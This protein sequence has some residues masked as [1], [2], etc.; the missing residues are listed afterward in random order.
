MPFNQAK[1]RDSDNDD[2]IEGEFKKVGLEGFALR[3]LTF[4]P[5]FNKHEGEVCQG[6]QIHPTDL[7]LFQPWKVGQLLC[8]KLYQKMEKLTSLI[9]LPSLTRS[10]V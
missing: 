9:F 2:W 10:Y 1:G 6:Y 4:I 7:K 8:Q 5:T 3:P